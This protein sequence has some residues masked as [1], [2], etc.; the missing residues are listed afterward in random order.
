PYPTASQ[1]GPLPPSP[2]L[3]GTKG[4]TLPPI[5]PLRSGDPFPPRQRS[6]GQRVRPCPLTPPLR[7]GAPFPLSLTLRGTKP[8]PLLAPQRPP[9]LLRGDRDLDVGA[10]EGIT[11]GIEHG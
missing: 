1:R 8:A 4:S 7:S 3:R 5:P 9:D 10:V 2:T 6:G 11:N